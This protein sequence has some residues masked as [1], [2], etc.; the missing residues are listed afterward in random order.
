MK[1]GMYTVLLGLIIGCGCG[2]GAGAGDDDVPL[3]APAVDAPK[4]AEQL[5]CEDMVVGEPAD[6]RE[7]IQTCLDAPW[8]YAFLRAEVYPIDGGLVIDAGDVLAG[9]APDRRATIQPAVASAPFAVV[10]NAILNVVNTTAGPA[11]GTL[12][13]V[14]LDL[15]DARPVPGARLFGIRIAF[16]DNLV[17]DVEITSTPMPW[18]EVAA[19][20]LYF[21]TGF[22]NKAQR[23]HLHGAAYGIAFVNGIT[24][25]MSPWVDRA[26]LEDNRGDAVTFAGYGKITNSIVRRNGFDDGDS[27]T[28]TRLPPGGALYA[29]H[30]NV[31]GGWIEGNQ[32]T[33]ACGADLELNMTRGFVVR[34]NVF[35]NPGWPGMNGMRSVIRPGELAYDVPAGFCRATMTAL[36]IALAGSE[37]RGNT[38]LNDNRPANTSVATSNGGTEEWFG[39]GKADLPL[40]EGTSIAVAFV[41]GRTHRASNG[42]VHYAVNN[43]FIGNHMSST[44]GA[45]GLGWI[46][47]RDTGFGPGGSW[48]TTTANVFDD[49][50]HCAPNSGPCTAAPHSVRCGDN[51]YATGT[52]TCVGPDGSNLF[53]GVAT[54]NSC[55]RDDITHEGAGHDARRNDGCLHY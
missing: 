20:S 35:A 7:R 23:L 19:T 11:G 6:N 41:L 34:D 37:F 12:R 27:G 31:H 38:F 24:A 1:L 44:S 26:K 29:S 2:D 49:N 5:G 55:N 15:R 46:A 47:G 16:D 25:E 53:D 4:S 3:D 14:T 10:S 21:G 51:R 30:V 22:R 18:R 43:A 8:G 45:A 13:N 42:M 32:I 9:P 39:P 54:G 40:P 52:A 17:E 48:D 33:D 36:L 28:G 50:S